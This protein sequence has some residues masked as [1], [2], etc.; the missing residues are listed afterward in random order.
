MSISPYPS[1]NSNS[2]TENVIEYCIMS[3]SC[4]QYCDFPKTLSD[5]THQTTPVTYSALTSLSTGEM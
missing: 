3:K 5:F 4:P 1:I 2:L